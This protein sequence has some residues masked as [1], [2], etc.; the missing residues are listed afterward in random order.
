MKFLMLVMMMSVAFGSA[1][2]VKVEVK[3][4]TLEVEN[5]TPASF[6]LRLKA[7]DGIHV[8]AV[9]P[10]TIKTTTDGAELSVSD[11]PRTGDYLDLGRPI[12]IQC[13]VTGLEPGL[14]RVDFVLGYT[15]CSD[16]EGW[17]RMGKDSTSIEIKVKK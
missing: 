14:H 16:N 4:A 3:P 12:K 9:P 11:L 17:C 7:G 13:K 6:E 15:Y 1:G 10:I 8:N 5:G 2:Y